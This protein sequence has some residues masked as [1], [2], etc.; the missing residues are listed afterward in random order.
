MSTASS[1]SGLLRPVLAHPTRGVVGLVD[2]L[3]A[4]CREHGLEL[5]WQAG[6]CRVRPRG[7]DWEEWVDVPLRKS[8]FRAVL[9]RLAAL[10]NERVPNSVSPYGGRGQFSTAADPAT[11]FTIAFTNTTAEQRLELA[12][13]AGPAPSVWHAPSVHDQ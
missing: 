2:D 5:D 4:T 9:A 13:E 3:L 7:G 6:R 10:C 12:A 8:V 11:V 1:F